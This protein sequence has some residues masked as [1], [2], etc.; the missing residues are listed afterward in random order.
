MKLRYT[1]RTIGLLAGIAAMGMYPFA[2]RAD[3]GMKSVPVL[4]EKGVTTVTG[5]ENWDTITGF[6]KEGIMA[7][8][9]TLMMV[10]GSG[11][12]HMRMSAMKPGM[13]MDDKSMPG[14]AAKSQGMPLTVTLKQ[15]PPVVGDNT[16]DI[17]VMDANGKPL[18]G[19]KLMSAVA[20]TSMDMGTAHPKVTEGKGGHY[21]VTTT[22]SMKGPWRVALMTDAKGD[23]TKAVQAALDFDVDGKTKWTPPKMA[24]GADAP[25]KAAGAD[26]SDWKI[27]VNTDT[28][29]LKSGK[30]ALDVTILDANGK[31]VTGA[32][33][34]GTVEMTSMDMGTTHP[35]AQEKK[36]GHYSVPVEFSM[37]GPWR[38]TLT[39]TPPRQKLFTK[40]FDFSVA[41]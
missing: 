17:M 34:T 4:Q 19:L 11:M 12:E 35:K 31:P 6:G 7:E 25:T 3:E 18:T 8:M 15:N 2:A 27:T 14:M 26:A 9:M 1:T 38:V 13:K 20:M 24:V 39:V 30:N 29:T 37:K 40:S 28:K 10:G 23:K 5:N 33:V 22:F 16:L 41:Q 21:T 32:K 36:D